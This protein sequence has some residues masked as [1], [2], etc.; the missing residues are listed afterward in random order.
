MKN[1]D[2]TQDLPTLICGV[3][4]LQ[5]MEHS[6]ARVAWSCDFSMRW[7][8]ENITPSKLDGYITQHLQLLA[9]FT[10]ARQKWSKQQ[11]ATIAWLIRKQHPSLTFPQF[12]LFIVQSM[13]GKFGKFY[14]KL[15]AVEFLTFLQKFLGDLDA[16]RRA[17]WE[18]RPPAN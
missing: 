11:L 2:N 13:A 5:T 10:T 3:E 15:D 4:R 17:N 8:S 9:D 1:T 7:L 6:F 18:T 16:W 14:D 12:Q